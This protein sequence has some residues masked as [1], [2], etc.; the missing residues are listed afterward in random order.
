[1]QTL[2]SFTLAM[3]LAAC[4]LARPPAVVDPGAPARW[5]TPVS[6]SA[7]L[8]H[9]GSE[10]ALS[11]WWGQFD[12]PVLL[13]LIDAAQRASPTLASA[14]VRI[15][16]ARAARTQAGAALLPTL[17]GTLSA[18]RSNSPFAGVS[19]ATGESANALPGV[20]TLQAGL[21]S[22]W[23]IDLFGGRLAGRE[24]A[25]YRLGR[26]DAQWHDARV[27]VAA[28]TANAYVGERACQRQLAVASSDARSRGE[29]AR[30]TDLSAKAGF[31]APAS[32]ALARASAADASARLTQQR[33]QCAVL[34][35]G[36]VAMTALDGPSLD[37]L[38][39]DVP[40]EHDPLVTRPLPVVDSVPARLLAQRPD[41]YASETAVAAASADVGAA[42]ADRYPRLSL[43]GSVAALQLRSG[44]IHQSL[45]TW[46]IG[47][48]AL[49]LPI[50][51]GGVRAANVAS[52]R[53]RYDEAVVLYRSSA[54]QA[55][56][57]VEVA[58]LNLRS[59]DGRE[60]DAMT[61][62][63]NYQASLDATQ[64]RYRAGLGTLFELEDARR[65]LFAAQTA[66]VSL[67]RERAEARVALYRATGGGWTGP[68]PADAAAVG[69]ADPQVAA[70][71]ASKAAN[72]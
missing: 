11:T 23:E 34:R 53:A 46:T 15:A 56:R 14:A 31:T 50:F 52:A 47:P 45:Q 33:S 12:D 44:G 48:V 19:G 70:T 59:T 8:P 72:P 58:L 10:T 4:S 41:V 61:A 2:L 66:R 32:A 69:H 68:A 13:Q 38:L 1:M 21:Q 62:V 71:S 54:R 35:R 60:T 64:A 42:E 16:D 36:L 3:L 30:L 55:V 63:D 65:T 24:A 29:T 57:E 6:D 17:D 25:G 26:A 9:S 67:R 27:S 49:S 37:A 40:A 5:Q 20:T 39:D 43:Q 51:D 18:Q 22:S 28:E 7:A